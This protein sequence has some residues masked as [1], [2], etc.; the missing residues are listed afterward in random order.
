MARAT[1]H[2]LLLDHD[3]TLVAT[4]ALRSRVWARAVLDVTGAAI[5]GAEELARDMGK[6]V[7]AT[8]LGRTAGDAALAAELVRVYRE[9]YFAASAREVAAFPGVIETLTALRARGVRLA[10]VTSKLRTGATMELERAELAALMDAVIGSEDVQQHKPH[11]E[12]LLAAL[13]LL[14]EPPAAAVMVGDT[15][16]DL[17]A[18]RAAGVR[19]A[20]ALWG[21]LDAPLLRR[22]QPDYL[23]DRPASLLELCP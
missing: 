22:H 12:P 19:A 9:R 18:A 21:A 20:A 14:G 23:L 4:F 3:D 15:P 16:A 8:A 10:V 5:D 11:P 2:C 17:L 6:T 1:P 7:E 13:A